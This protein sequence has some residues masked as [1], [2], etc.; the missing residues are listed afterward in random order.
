MRLTSYAIFI[1]LVFTSA[2]YA[3]APSQYGVGFQEV[4]TN[5]YSRSFGGRIGRP[6][7][8]A[9][10]Y[11]ARRINERRFFKFDRYLELSARKTEAVRLGNGAQAELR[12]KWTSEFAGYNV[13]EASIQYLIN[14]E[15]NVAEEVRWAEGKFPLLIYG[16]G[17]GGES[18]ENHL[19]AEYFAAR[20]WIVA[21]VSSVGPQ[22]AELQ[23]AP[24]GLEAAARDI[25][26]AIQYVASTW[27]ENLRLENIS[28]AGWSWGALAAM[29]VESR[30]TNISMVISLDGSIA[31]Q[32]RNID[33]FASFDPSRTRSPHIFITVPRR[34]LRH[35]A[36]IDETK[37]ARSYL[38]TLAGATHVDF[39]SYRSMAHLARRKSEDIESAETGVNFYADLIELLFELLSDN[40]ATR[41]VSASALKAFLNNHS[42]ATVYENEPLPIPIDREAFLALLTSDFELAMSKAAQI[43]S[44]DPDYKILDWPDY[45]EAAYVL[46][47]DHEMKK[48]TIP[49]LEHAVREYPH[50]YQLVGQL[51]RFHERLGNLETAIDLFTQ[52]KTMAANVAPSFDRAD[53]LQFYNSRLGK[54]RDKLAAQ[55]E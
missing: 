35:R 43:K 27:P 3:A 22:S 23:I 44:L 24:D 36:F 54:I 41:D 30:N 38:I 51:A 19:L 39:T 8:I 2:S 28:L 50:I 47:F 53:N 40:G 16:A 5:D 45:V 21:A 34:Q 31:M 9:V 48:E 26:F 15:T 32:R 12:E 37:Y 46:Y 18:F 10:W 17:A 6:V 1:F 52:A 42:G 11:P 29:L 7:Q 33:A 14:A 25:E 49:L 13:P 20:G 55:T 4:L